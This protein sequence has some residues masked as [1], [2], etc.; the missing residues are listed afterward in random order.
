MAG[1]SDGGELGVGSG[2][3]LAGV[4]FTGVVV[5]AADGV[6]VAGSRQGGV[7]GVADVGVRADV[8]GLYVAVADAVVD[9]VADVVELGQAGAVAWAAAGAT[10]RAGAECGVGRVRMLIATA[11]VSTATTVP[12][13]LVSL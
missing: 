4:G 1:G 7:V 6:D 13:A 8:A 2:V 3:V 10:G 11:I 12:S 9:V 5:A